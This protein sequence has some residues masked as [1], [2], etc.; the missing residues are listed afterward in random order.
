MQ[1]KLEK[2]LKCKAITYTFNISQTNKEAI[3]SH[4]MAIKLVCNRL[5]APTVSTDFWWS[6][7]Q[8]LYSF[9]FV[10]LFVCFIFMVN[11]KRTQIEIVRIFPSKQNKRNILCTGAYL[12]FRRDDHL[13]Y[14]RCDRIIAGCLFVHTYV[15]SWVMANQLPQSHNQITD[16]KFP[17]SGTMILE[18]K[19]TP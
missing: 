9:F 13:F 4:Y 14:N 17:A 6:Y 15:C 7:G 10:C 8:E 1:I 3:R 18:D 16:W 19:K 5:I 2:Q 11:L 12:L